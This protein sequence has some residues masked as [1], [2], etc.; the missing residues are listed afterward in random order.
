MVCGDENEGLSDGKYAEC[1]V[2]ECSGDWMF[3]GVG[4]DKFC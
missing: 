3:E 2:G 4:W 1:E